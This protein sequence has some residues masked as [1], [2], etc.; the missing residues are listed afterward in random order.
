MNYSTAI[1]IILLPLA[2]FVLLGL[3]KKYFKNI[4]GILST[5]LLF[6][7]AGLALTIAYHY[8]LLTV[9]KTAFIKQ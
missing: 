8:F 5:A 7:A 6:I 1:W 3:G 2:N 9:N 4:A